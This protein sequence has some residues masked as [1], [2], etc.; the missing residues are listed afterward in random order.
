MIIRFTKSNFSPRQILEY[1]EWTF[2][3]PYQCKKGMTLCCRD[4]VP[5][6]LTFCGRG[7]ITRGLLTISL[8]FEN[9]YR[10][11]WNAQDAKL[12][13]AAH[14]RLN[15]ERGGGEAFQNIFRELIRTSGD[16]WTPE[17]PSTLISLPLSQT[18]EEAR[19]IHRRYT[20]AADVL[21]VF[22]F[23]EALQRDPVYSIRWPAKTSHKTG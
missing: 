5:N 23:A 12:I 11:K 22:S 14:T 20:R 3:N 2:E 18:R 9:L 15:V 6:E 8:L 4:Y 13:R 19:Q 16:R 17:G 7:N 10:A 1:I 21:P